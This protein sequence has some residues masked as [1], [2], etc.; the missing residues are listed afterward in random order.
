MSKAAS[1][2]GL[3]E[4]YEF[5]QVNEAQK[6]QDDI[7]AFE[8]KLNGGQPETGAPPVKPAGSIPDAG[9]PRAYRA[10]SHP[11]AVA[12]SQGNEMSASVKQTEEDIQAV[13]DL[14]KFGADSDS[15]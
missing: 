12:P 9:H 11:V 8:N 14:S 4:T 15:D 1:N 6:A 3:N 10:G 7:A 13:R 5:E 2:K